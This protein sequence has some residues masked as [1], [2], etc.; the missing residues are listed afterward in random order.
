MKKIRLFFRGV[1]FLAIL[2]GVFTART[3]FGHASMQG[4]SYLPDA[5]RAYSAEEGAR[6][7][8][9]PAAVVSQITQ[10]PEDLPPPSIRFDRITIADGLSFSKVDAILQDRQGFMW[11]GTERGLNKYDGY[12][13]T[14][15]RNDP[16]D[17]GSLS[18][19]RIYALY[20]NSAGELWV[21]TAVGLDRLDRTTDTF[22]HYQAGVGGNPFTGMPNSGASVFAIQEDRNGVLWVGGMGGLY[23]LDPDTQILTRSPD[24]QVVEEIAEN[25]NGQLWVADIDGLY[26]Y[27]PQTDQRIPAVLGVQSEYTIYVDPRGD[28]WFG[29]SDGLR[30]IDHSTGSVVHYQHNLEDSNSLGDD[31][32]YALFEDGAGRLW[33]G[34]SGG[35]DL[36][37]RERDRF[38]H[39]RFDPSDPYSLSDDNIYSLYEDRSGVLWIGTNRG[40]SKYSWAAN[41]FTLYTRLPVAPAV[42]L[43][44]GHLLKTYGLQSLSNDL[45]LAVHEDRE[46]I[47]WVGMFDGGLNRLNR[48]A[49]TIT[50]YRY[51]PDNPNS[52]S[53]DTVRE[54]YQDCSGALWVGTDGGLNQF[55]PGNQVFL[56]GWG[57]SIPE[58]VW[59]ITEDRSGELWIGS[60][61]DLYSFDRELG[62]FIPFQQS[63]WSA[64]AVRSLYADE[65]GSLWV[66]TQGAGLY[67]WDG[68]QVTSY[69]PQT[70]NPYNASG[71]FIRSIYTDPA[72]DSG[73]VWAGT[74]VGGL[75]RFDRATPGSDFRQYTEKDGLAG[76]RV[77][78]IMA[79]ADGFLW[80]ATNRGVSRFDPEAQSFRNYDARDGLQNGET[81]DCFQSSSGEMFLGGMGGLAAFHPEQIKENAQ[82]PPIAITTFRLLNENEPRQ[83]P[84]DGRVQLSYQQN[85]LSFE[86][87]AL[88]YHA[89]GKNQYAYRMDNVDMDWV[90]AGT[91]R[92]VNYTNLQPGDYVFRVKGSNNDG[93]W[94]EE[95]VTLHITIQPPFWGTW[96]FRGLVAVLLVSAALGTYR[97]R[98]RSIEA[99]SLEL[100]QQ[101]ADR[102][103]ELSQANELLEQEIAERMR[104]EEALAQERASAAVTAER[105]RLARELH[106]AV[107]QTLFSASLVA[108][109]LPAAWE[110]DPEEGHGLLKDLRGLSRGA[111]AEMRTLLLELRP[112]ALLE[113]RLDDLLRQ[114]GEAT[115]GRVGIP[116]TVQIEG[117]TELHQEALPPDVHITL[118]RITQ[119]ALNN[120]IKHA[121]A[122]QVTVRLDYS[123]ESRAE[124]LRVSLSISDDGRGFDATQLQHDR[125]GFGIMQERIQAIGG[126]LTIESQ[127]GHGTRVTV[128]WQQA[129]RLEA[130]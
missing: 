44:S 28:V 88:D 33:V 14:V 40:L 96:W 69:Q 91:R 43:E 61:T 128:L 109:A 90:A 68:T 82:P 56:K 94:N 13:F 103:A 29:A 105:N 62:R 15:Y 119:E 79:D 101:V 25:I 49:G 34:T 121:R 6:T 9:P 72:M 17:P 120:V 99:R 123:P 110:K 86:F 122:H 83:L 12:Q 87:A 113:T 104:T 130:T 42:S 129:K 117:E 3:A 114:L 60:W 97:L 76:Y 75:L 47:L 58:I 32:V 118:Y 52:L 93:V 100:E 37:D 54:I 2:S 35:L 1:I 59:A 66:G 64:T 65:A 39:Y 19:D 92:Y 16:A 78:C 4:V 98:V 36:F 10:T 50:V 20:E 67:R 70:S 63:G 74:D 7:T 81:L 127:P 48:T 24:W 5:G 30:R 51:D 107:T 55:E 71:G 89:P 85:D 112:A 8:T 116:V 38:V 11:F 124:P 115:S 21:G 84:P 46:D 41:R 73:A 126:T 57:L 22:V 125:L 18:H 31:S 26:L 80:L 95:G 27:D 45:V 23:H 106:D 108:E 77:Q 102:T 53:S 111:L